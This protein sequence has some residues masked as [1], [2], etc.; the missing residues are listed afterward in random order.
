MWLNLPLLVS[1][2]CAS[3]IMARTFFVGSYGGEILTVSLDENTHALKN[4]STT[5]SSSP[6]PSWQELGQHNTILYTVEEQAHSAPFSGLGAV[7]SYRILAG[8][9]LQK[10]SSATSSSAP[11]S[12][13]LS[14]DGK[15]IF[16]A[17]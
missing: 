10:I 15:T 1:L 12:L 9:A 2:F 16:T 5:L 17:N 8:G 11:V 6:S 7:A 14:P 4:T 3:P 13:G